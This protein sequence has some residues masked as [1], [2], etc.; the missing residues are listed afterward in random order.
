MKKEN[1]KLCD[2]DLDLACMQIFVYGVGEKSLDAISVLFDSS[3]KEVGKP[4][5]DAELEKLGYKIIELGNPEGYGLLYS[6]FTLID[7]EDKA[8][9]INDKGIKEGCKMCVSNKELY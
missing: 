3:K 5:E 4:K 2:L 8:E 1:Q 6:Y 7:Q 9:A